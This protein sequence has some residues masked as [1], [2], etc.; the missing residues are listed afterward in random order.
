MSGENRRQ[1][2]ALA[3]LQEVLVPAARLMIANGVQLPAMVEV[4]KQVLVMEAHQA[5]A[6]ERYSDTRIAV[7]TGVHRKDVK[8]LA[9]QLGDATSG[10]SDLLTSVA[11]QVVGRWISDPAFLDAQ[12]AP[13]RLARTPRYAADDSPSFSGLVGLVSKDVGARAVL[14]GL[15]RLD[16]VRAVDETTVELRL[17]AFVPSKAARESLYFLAANVSDHLASAVHNQTPDPEGG[18]MLE[19]SAFSEGLTQEQAE[20][21]HQLAR[22]WWERALKQFLQEATIAEAQRPKPGQAAYRVRFGVYFH[23][24]AKESGRVSQGVAGEVAVVARKK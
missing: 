22:N 14:D 10:D 1:G 4:L 19:Q 16:V 11:S 12:G 23:Q 15:L 2:L 6:G 7:M 3:A 20:R 8:R 18:P 24:A 5:I 21:L 9:E 13:L 17:R